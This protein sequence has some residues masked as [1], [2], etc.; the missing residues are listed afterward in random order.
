M[1]TRS[2]MQIPLTMLTR[3]LSSSPWRG[4]ITVAMLVAGAP[5]AFSL[6]TSDAD[7]TY[8]V[9]ALGDCAD[10]AACF[11][12][13]EVP[14]NYA[15]CFRFAK[16]HNLLKGDLAERDEE[17]LEELAS[18][19][20]EGGPGGCET[21]AICRSYC[22]D[23]GH[24]DE[25]TAFAEKHG[26]ISDDEL[27]EARKVKAALEQGAKL[28]GGCRSKD[29]CE[30]YCKDSDE[31]MEECLAFAEKAGFMKKE[32]RESARKFL[33]LMQSGETPGGCRNQRACEDYCKDSDHSKECFAFAAK[34]E[35]VPLEEHERFREMQRKFE[36]GGPGGCKSQRECQ[37]FCQ[38]PSHREECETFF[39]GFGDSGG[40]PGEPPD[41]GNFI[42]RIPPEIRG[43][44]QSAL[45]EEE[46]RAVASGRKTAA[47]EGKM[48]ACFRQF[49]GSESASAL[50]GDREGG[51]GRAGEGEYRP[52][53]YP[54]G[55]QPP[56][57]GAFPEKQY[58]EQYRAESEEQYRQQ[59]EQQYQQQYQQP[60]EQQ[61][62]QQHDQYR[63]QYEANPPSPAVSPSPPPE[64]L[65]N[66]PSL[67]HRLVGLVFYGLF[68]YAQ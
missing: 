68:G 4:A 62:Q 19:L 58:E 67:L 25:C 59:Y 52:P 31:H 9:D 16:Q 60:Y 54:Q 24:M 20:K 15:A 43:C 55:T 30:A 18:A 40:P 32:E 64:S 27:K 53:E 50:G 38:D 2:D 11:Q 21:E 57:T 28:P 23:I 34:A 37:A 36:A 51:D 13:C 26:F 39:R 35:F 41:T 6:A 1:Q 3:I 48:S 17:D 44:I 47:I 29:A 45:T 46:L 7:I 49:G 8:P 33:D 5:F 63:E 42:E 66:S 61:Y 56:P 10:R 12:Y 14:D 22:D 65:L